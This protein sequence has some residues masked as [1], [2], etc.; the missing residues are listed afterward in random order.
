[1]TK[2]YLKGLHT[3]ETNKQ[4]INKFNNYSTIKEFLNDST[5]YLKVKFNELNNIFLR[6]KRSLNFETP[7]RVRIEHEY[8]VK[9]ENLNLKANTPYFLINPISRLDWLQIFCDT[10]HISIAGADEI[11]QIVL[12]TMKE[13]IEKYASSSNLNKKEVEND[14][15][16]LKQGLPCFIIFPE[17]PKTNFIIKVKYYEAIYSTCTNKESYRLLNPIR[18]REISYEYIPLSNRT[19]W[20]YLQAPDNFEITLYENEK[21]IEK[22]GTDPQVKSHAKTDN[23]KHKYKIVISTAQSLNYWY[24]VIYYASAINCILLLLIIGNLLLTKLNITVFNSISIQEL[25]PHKLMSSLVTFIGAAIITTRSFLIT[26]ETML[27]YYLMYL[28]TL[29]L[30]NITLYIIYSI[31]I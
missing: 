19:S 12:N 9:Q 22:K 20:L 18:K 4:Y 11:K 17:A 26:E 15:W 2:Y 21:I 3:V 30:I 24:N 25:I 13:D 8:D 10:T 27:K 7:N 31:L 1:M 23:K 14:I 29:F 28:T 16:D 5:T 6:E